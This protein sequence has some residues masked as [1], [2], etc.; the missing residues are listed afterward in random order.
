MRLVKAVLV[1][2]LYPNVAR[3]DAGG[4]KPGDGKKPKLTTRS[5]DGKSGALPY[6]N[7]NPI[8]ADVRA[9][10]PCRRSGRPVLADVPGAPCCRRSRGL[11]EVWG[12]SRRRCWTHHWVDS[13]WKASGG[14]AW[15]KHGSGLELAAACRV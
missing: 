12:R 5:A 3:V 13:A 15:L 2:G 9:R 10:R 1:A 11:A 4:G 6:P 7:P 8:L 14:G